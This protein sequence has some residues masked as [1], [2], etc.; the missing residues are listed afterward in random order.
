MVSQD[1]LFFTKLTFREMTHTNLYHFA[2]V[3][4]HCIWPRNNQGEKKESPREISNVF[5][6]QIFST[7]EHPTSITPNLQDNVTIVLSYLCKD[8]LSNPI[9]NGSVT[10]TISMQFEEFKNYLH[11]M[12][13]PCSCYHQNFHSSLDHS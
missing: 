5:L 13:P 1:L 7:T 8:Y 6:T 11:H 10:Q 4:K 3:L 9:Y 2:N 12:V